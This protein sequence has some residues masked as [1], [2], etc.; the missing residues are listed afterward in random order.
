MTKC[1]KFDAKP[2]RL[3]TLARFVTNVVTKRVERSTR[4]KFGH[5]FARNTI[6]SFS[7]PRQVVCLCHVCARSRVCVGVLKRTCFCAH[8][9][10]C[11]PERTCLRT[12][13]CVDMHLSVAARTRTRVC[14]CVL[15]LWS[16]PQSALNWTSV[17]LWVDYEA[18]AACSSVSY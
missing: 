3:L 18:T 13:M 11:V 15:C 14:C 8:E 12:H 16:L 17:L 2:A 1:V 10:V 4:C 9:C 7:F 5:S 6:T